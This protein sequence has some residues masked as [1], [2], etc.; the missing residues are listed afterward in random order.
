LS[1]TSDRPTPDPR[2]LTLRAAFVPDGGTP[3][4]ELNGFDPL[5]IPATVDPST[6]QITSAG[7]GASFDGDVRA[8]WHPDEEDGDAWDGEPGDGDPWDGDPWDDDRWDTE[9][10]GEDDEEGLDPVFD[11]AVEGSDTDGDT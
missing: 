6:G 10:A 4:A 1:D 3:P 5:R 11:G 7:P 8:E 9:D 2:V